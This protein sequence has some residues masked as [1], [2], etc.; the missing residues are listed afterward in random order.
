MNKM[1]DTYRTKGLRKHLVEDLKNKGIK[2]TNV[3]DAIGNIPRHYFVPSSLFEH[4]YM[5]T[6]LPIACNQTISQP[7]TVARQS[8]LLEI[9][10]QLRI[11]EIGTGSGYQA[12]ILRYMG[13]FVYSIERQRDLY[14]HAKELFHTLSIS[15]ASKHGDGYNGWSE[16][17]PFDR[18]LVTC[19]AIE[20]PQI[21]LIQL[22]IN[23]ILVAPVGE[24]GQQIMT[25]TIR[26]SDT[27]FETTTH[28][29]FR[30]VP[31]LKNAE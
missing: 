30:F 22:K 2:D 28:G 1:T 20:I 15:I 11:L 13:A 12:A 3:L 27:D 6:P 10:K 19:G 25:K 16:F 14:E 17:A 31:M 5:D 18:I 23:G 9:K 29:S 7:Y 26:L 4:A 21:L 8:E 24:P